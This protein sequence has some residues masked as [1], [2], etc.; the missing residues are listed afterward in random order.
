LYGNQPIYEINE[1]TENTN[2]EIYSANQLNQIVNPQA[3]QKKT[4]GRKAKEPTFNG[5]SLAELKKIKMSK[6]PAKRAMYEVVMADEST[7]KMIE[8]Q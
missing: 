3:P 7:R 1:S 8:I 6:D 5:M 2:S 4:R